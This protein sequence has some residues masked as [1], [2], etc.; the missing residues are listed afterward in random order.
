MSNSPGLHVIIAEWMPERGEPLSV[1]DVSKKFGITLQQAMAFLTILENDNAIETQRGHVIPGTGHN[2]CRRN[3]RTIKVI[4]ID[5]D[6]IDQR[7]HHYNTYRH[8]PLKLTDDLSRSEK[9]ELIIRNSRWRK[10]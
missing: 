9:W 5:R 6:K 7:Q 2:A 4:S 3:T 1:H 8:C 10:K